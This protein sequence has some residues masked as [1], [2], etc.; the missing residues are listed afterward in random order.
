MVVLWKSRK[1]FDAADKTKL[2][3]KLVTTAIG[4]QTKEIAAEQI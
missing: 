1:K 2:T 3:T 4:N